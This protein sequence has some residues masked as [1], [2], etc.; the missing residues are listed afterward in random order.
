MVGGTQEIVSIEN[1]EA[2]I[3]AHGDT[4]HGRDIFAPAAALLASGEALLEDLGPVVDPDTVMPLL[5][6]LPELGGKRAVGEVWWVDRFGNC[7][8]NIGPADLDS[9]GL[10]PGGSVMIRVG[11]TEHPAVWHKAYGDVGEGELLVHVDSAG[12]VALAVRG[13]SAAEYLNLAD[14]TAVTL[15]GT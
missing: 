4:F 14:G 5:L 13:G 9:L 15:A 12:L 7:Q 10:A 8:T 3:P 1:P 11:A 6:P 2:R